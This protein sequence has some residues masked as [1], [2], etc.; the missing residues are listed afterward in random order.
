MEPAVEREENSLK[1]Y[2]HLGNKKGQ[3]RIPVV[4]VLLCP[5]PPY[6]WTAVWGGVVS[7]PKLSC[8]AGGSREKLPTFTLPPHHQFARLDQFVTKSQFCTKIGDF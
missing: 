2:L 5:S 4:A 7:L 8:R 1:N 6:R 3:D